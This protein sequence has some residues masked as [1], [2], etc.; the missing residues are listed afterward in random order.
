[1]LYSVV[2]PW[3]SVFNHLSLSV[4]SLELCSLCLIH[5]TNEYV[6]VN[7]DLQQQQKSMSDVCKHWLWQNQHFSTVMTCFDSGIMT[8]YHK[9]CPVK[10]WAHFQLQ[11]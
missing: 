11:Q 9:H 10:H 2:A 5:L 4:V 3:Y 7:I 8:H 6:C 1:M